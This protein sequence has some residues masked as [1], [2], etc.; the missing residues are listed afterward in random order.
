[1]FI[2]FFFQLL[3]FGFQLVILSVVIPL[4]HWVQPATIQIF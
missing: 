3:L 1:L 2:F 4:Q